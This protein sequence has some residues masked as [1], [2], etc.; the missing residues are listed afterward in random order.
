MGKSSIINTLTETAVWVDTE[1]AEIQAVGEVSVRNGKGK[2]TTRHI[3]FI[4]LAEG[5]LL[6]DTP[7]FTQPTLDEVTPTELGSLFPEI[8]E[9]LAAGSCRFKDC[10]HKV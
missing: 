4:R 9:A 1:P 10:L 6:A 5:G 3:S 7:G 2:H 8:R